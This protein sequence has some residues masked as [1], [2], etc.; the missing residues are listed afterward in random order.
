MDALLQENTS[1]LPSKPMEDHSN[2]SDMLEILET[3]KPQKQVLA[4][5][6]M[7]ITSLRSTELRIMSLVEQWLCI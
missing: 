6:S 3:L 7:K 5:M 1:I 4:I 2:Q